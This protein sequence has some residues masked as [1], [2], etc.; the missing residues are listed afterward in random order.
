MM[1]VL[2]E[3][4]MQEYYIKKAKECEMAVA[5]LQNQ[6]ERMSREDAASLQAQMAKVR[7]EMK[8]YKAAVENATADA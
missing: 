5:A 3:G 4:F 6:I 7:R 1:D 2:A 8:N